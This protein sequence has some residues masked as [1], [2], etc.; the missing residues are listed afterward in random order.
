MVTPDFGK[1]LT[2]T[3]FILADS[4]PAFLERFYL[5]KIY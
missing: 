2:L 4:R 3:K 1:I 5:L